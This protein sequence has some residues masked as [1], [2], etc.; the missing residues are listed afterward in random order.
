M[1][2]GKGSPLD[3]ERYDFLDENDHALQKLR[4]F[5][6]SSGPYAFICGLSQTP[7]DIAALLLKIAEENKTEILSVDNM[8]VRKQQSNGSK[9][10][11][12]A[13]IQA[14]KMEVEK[15][16]L[17]APPYRK[18]NSNTKVG[19]NTLQETASEPPRSIKPRV[20]VRLCSHF[21]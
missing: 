14:I 5:F 19:A 9:Q 11:N 8:T 21:F 18:P 7:S 12:R 20:D 2:D 4:N 15:K 6:K 3:E 16:G 1:A 10:T 17:D 13:E